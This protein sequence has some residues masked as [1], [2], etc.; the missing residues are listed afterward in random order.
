MEEPINPYESPKSN[1]FELEETL[2]PVTVGKII[3][4]LNFFVDYIMQVILIM[5]VYFL[6]LIIGGESAAKTIESIPQFFLG[7]ISL[8]LYYIVMEAST[9]RTVGKM[10]T[11]TK[12]VD[13]EGRT[14]TFGQVIGRTFARM[15]PFEALTFLGSETRGWHDSMSNTYVVK[16]R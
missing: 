3:R 7:L 6:F 1:P 4:L 5:L 14:P 15:I 9:G 8:L 12:V 16:C 11:G 13:E 2:E 10:V